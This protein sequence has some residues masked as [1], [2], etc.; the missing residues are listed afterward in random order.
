MIDAALDIADRD[1]PR[2]Q[3]MHECGSHRAD[4]AKPL[5]YQACPLNRHLLPGQASC[6]QYTTPRPVAS[7]RPSDPPMTMGLPVTTPG[8]E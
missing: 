6:T 1:D 2:A 4:I 3:L 8:T 5:Y 7:R